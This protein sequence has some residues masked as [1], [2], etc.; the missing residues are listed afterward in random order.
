VCRSMAGQ[1]RLRVAQQPHNA[2]YTTEKLWCAAYVQENNDHDFNDPTYDHFRN[3]L[4]VSHNPYGSDDNLICSH[5]TLQ[6][7]GFQSLGHSD[8]HVREVG[9][10][11]RLFP[12]PKP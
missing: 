9:L 2:Q 1:E 4:D 6:S 3:E 10:Q 7:R 8:P 5:R 11:I 12:L